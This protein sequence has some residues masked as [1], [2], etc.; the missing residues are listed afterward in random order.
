MS[1]NGKVFIDRLDNRTRVR[2]LTQRVHHP[3]GGGYNDKL[4]EP[5]IDT[6]LPGDLKQVLV[7][8]QGLRLETAE[9]L[10]A[11]EVMV[12]QCFA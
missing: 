3:I 1:I 4:S 2:V 8:V 12:R 9:E 5:L 11:G 10:S 7:G 6:N